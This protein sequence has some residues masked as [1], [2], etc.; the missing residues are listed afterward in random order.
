MVLVSP[1]PPTKVVLSQEDALRPKIAGPRLSILPAAGATATQ[2]LP[3]FPS[4]KSAGSFP[5]TW[6]A[7]LEPGLRIWRRSPRLPINQ[8][9]LFAELAEGKERR[10]RPAWQPIPRNRMGTTFPFRQSEGLPGVT[11]WASPLR[12]FPFPDPAPSRRLPEGKR[13]VLAGRPWKT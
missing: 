7:G 2:A 9:T 3:G 5:L 11:S 13:G 4:P 6:H 12:G 1:P 10:P 8:P